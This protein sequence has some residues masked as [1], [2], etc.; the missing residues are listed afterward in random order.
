MDRSERDVVGG[1]AALPLQDVNVH[2]RLVV[3]DSIKLLRAAGGNHR[4]SLKDRTKMIAFQS[5]SLR[6]YGDFC[7]QSERTDIREDHFPD[8]LSSLL[9]G[10]LN[11]SS[12]RH[13]LIRIDTGIR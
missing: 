13:C 11:G 3:V 9:H 1:E 7:P 12:Q 10:S 8:G 5:V 6:P 4:I 2:L